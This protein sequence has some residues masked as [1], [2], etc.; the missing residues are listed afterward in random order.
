MKNDK[1]NNDIK[2]Q[3]EERKKIESLISFEKTFHLVESNILELLIQGWC[4]RSCLSI[5]QEDCESGVGARCS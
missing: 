4:I 3:K 5:D 1:T 2:W